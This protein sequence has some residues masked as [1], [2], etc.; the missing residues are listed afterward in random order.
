VA[1]GYLDKG[2][3]KISRYRNSKDDK[4]K[5]VDKF[6]DSSAGYVNERN[7]LIEFNSVVA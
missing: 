3:T 7:V 1:I 6:Q 4:S 2:T 5:D